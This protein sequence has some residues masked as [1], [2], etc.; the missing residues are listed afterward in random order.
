MR[1]IPLRVAPLSEQKRIVEAVEARFTR[2]EAA[3][4]ALERVRAKLKQYRASVLRAACEGRLAGLGLSPTKWTNGQLG[5]VLDSI[6]NGIYRPPNVYSEDGVTCLRMYNIYEGRLLMVDLKHMRLTPA[7][8]DEYELRPGDVLVNRVNSRGIVGKA[9]CVPDNL[10]LLVYESKNMRLRFKDGVHPQFAT[11]WLNAIGIP[12]FARNSQQVVGMASIN[13]PQVRDLPF[14]LPPPDEQCRIVAEVERRLSVTDEITTEVDMG[15]RRCSR[16]RSS[17]LRR[18][19]DGR[20]VPQNP[21]D[22]PAHALLARISSQPQVIESPHPRR[23][24][25]PAA[26]AS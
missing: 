25:R 2:V 20:L 16:L 24:R 18:A 19:F 6:K 14:R 7:E 26:P 11:Y 3:V 9:A 5:G 23:L 12:H 15:L 13:Q 10:G 8:I 22:E 21:N 4:A 1:Q 17:I